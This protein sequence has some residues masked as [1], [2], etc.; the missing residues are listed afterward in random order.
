M[1]VLPKRWSP[2]RRAL[3]AG[4]LSGALWAAGN[5]LSTGFLITFLAMELGAQGFAVAAILAI[6][7]LVSLLR[8]ST[9]WWVDWFGSK[10]VVWLA[11][12][13]VSYGLL[14]LL[15]FTITLPHRLDRVDPL[16]VLIVILAIHQTFESLA[17]VALWSWLGDLVPSAIR[18]RYFGRRQ[19]LQLV[20][21]T[22]AVP[23]SGWFIDHWK[24]QHPQAA[25]QL[26][27]YAAVIGCSALLLLLSLVPL[28]LAPELPPR[29]SINPS[30]PSEQA[31]PLW[32]PQPYR[33]LLAFTLGF[34]VANGFTQAA[35]NRY[36][37]EVLQLG[38]FELTLMVTVMRVGQTL[39]TAWLGPL[40]D[41]RGNRPI[42][43]ACQLVVASGMLF[44]ALASPA[45][46]HWLWGAWFVWIAFAG[47]NLCQNNLLLKLVPPHRNTF[48]IAAQ[49][50]L[51]AVGF[52]FSALA[53]GWLLD[54]LRASA[55]SDSAPLSLRGVYALLFLGGWLIR[56]LVAG[57]LWPIDER[58]T[59]RSDRRGA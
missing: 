32:R 47:H 25:E 20:C 45:A 31:E 2:R 57:L 59:I 23:L 24:T 55:A 53:G 50:A 17:A 3:F 51:S 49:Q 42:L 56:S 39:L 48:P 11:A 27:G 6:Q 35:Q 38:L 18:G 34:S 16:T 52:A 46:P 4:H 41:R 33:W 12:S 30:R 22:I 8:L 1:N 28:A 19:M 37:R 21:I 5:A 14:A 36:P 54:Q 43:I 10:K 13:L 26:L 9:P 15:P 29:R 58:A 44:Y 7:S 40:S